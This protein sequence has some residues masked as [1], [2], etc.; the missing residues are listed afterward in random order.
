MIDNKTLQE[1]LDNKLITKQ[2]HPSLD[3][4][5]Y[6]YTPECVFSKKWDKVTKT[7]RGLILDINNEIV[8][9]PFE[10]FFNYGEIEES[11]PN[12]TPK[13]YKK[14]DGSLIIVTW[15]N[16]DLIVSTRGSFVSEQSQ[17]AR[18]ILLANYPL[19]EKIKSDEGFTYLFEYTSPSNRI[20]ILYPEERLTLL[21]VIINWDG[22]ECN[23]DYWRS[24]DFIKVVDEYK[25]EW[26]EDTI[27]QLLDLNLNNEEGFVLRWDNNFR[28]K[29][30][31]AEYFRLHKLITGLNEKT[32]WEFLCW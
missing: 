10:K 4:F 15:Y 25:A 29:V 11:L 12:R 20:V 21:A 26:S 19:I 31:F 27:Q 2:K 32:I 23:L 6:N 16:N 17:I 3:L 7:C 5:I 24:F 30:K 22:R 9:R 8:A 14:L 1:Y 28:V 13:I 18:K